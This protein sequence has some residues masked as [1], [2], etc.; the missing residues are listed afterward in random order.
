MFRYI[1]LHGLETGVDHFL[2]DSI[3][4]ENISKASHK[5]NPTPDPVFFGKLRPNKLDSGIEMFWILALKYKRSQYPNETDAG[6]PN[7]YESNFIWNRYL[8]TNEAQAGINM[9]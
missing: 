3:Y 6:F 2:N 7:K 5:L 1:V 9:E 8:I 4:F